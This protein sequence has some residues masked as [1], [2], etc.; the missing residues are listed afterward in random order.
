MAQN[1]NE[2]IDQFAVRLRRK[3][4]QCD[5]GDQL[6]SQIRDQII[7]KCRSSDLRRKFLERGQTPY[8]SQ[9]QEIA[10]TSEAV[11]R[12]AKSMNVQNDG[13]NRVSEKSGRLNRYESKSEKGGRVKKS[14]ECFRCG[15]P[16]HFA[17]DPK[18]PAKG[19]ECSKCHQKGHFAVVCKTKNKDYGR[20]YV[21]FVEEEDKYAFAVKGQS[22]TGK[23]EV[24]V[25]GVSVEMVIDSGA[26]TNVIDKYLW[27]K[28]KKEGH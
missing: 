17:R 13:M 23:V 10:R 25:G 14:G 16:G 27:E 7:S 1:E 6:E 26:S 22:E 4:Q 12:Q 20:H 9:L 28:L 18:C 5:Y 15:K 8:L 11:K 24:S 19:K 3:A 21:S 2:T